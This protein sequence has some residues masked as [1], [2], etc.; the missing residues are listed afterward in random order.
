MLPHDENSRGE[1]N[2][3]LDY[4]KR[5]GYHRQGRSAVWLHMSKLRA[6][7][8]TESD[9]NLA[10][11]KARDLAHRYQGEVFHLYNDD[12]VITLKDAKKNVTNSV[13]G[14]IRKIFKHDPLVEGSP[15]LFSDRYDMDKQYTEFLDLVKIIRHNV[16][17]DGVLDGRPEEIMRDDP[18]VVHTITGVIDPERIIEKTDI[19]ELGGTLALKRFALEIYPLET[20]LD[21]F[22]L[23][24]VDILSNPAMRTYAA[25]LLERRLLAAAPH[26]GV[27]WPM[28]WVMKARIS[29]L[30]SVDF[31]AFDRDWRRRWNHGVDDAVPA[32]V[33]S[34]GDC[35]S[36]ESVFRFAAD[37]VRERG[38]ALWL[39]EIS[40]FTLPSIN[41]GTYGFD[42]IKLDWPGSAEELGLTR[43]VLSRAIKRIGGDRIILTGCDEDGS[44]DLAI[45]LGIRYV[46]GSF[47]DSVFAGEIGWRA[48]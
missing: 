9:L 27:P 45:E 20:A 3:L 7:I 19:F 4:A 29:T 23:K 6:D 43:E 35:F 14:K 21:E 40:K 39:D 28:P 31:M 11:G 38:Y 32:F 37:F 5:V 36:D 42:M 34:Y 30:L 41:L 18:G 16:G 12:L 48:A 24:G 33:V 15:E 22:M 8:R 44:L 17:S 2:L 25:D 10:L 1:E 47:A 13:V 26:L 46:Q